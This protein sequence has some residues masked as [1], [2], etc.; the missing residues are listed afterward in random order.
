MLFNFVDATSISF[1]RQING[2]VLAPLAT[3]SNSTPIEGSVAVANFAQGG[4][5]HLGTFLGQG[6][7]D[8]SSRDPAR[9][10]ERSLGGGLSAPTPE[11]ATWAL[12]MIGIGMAGGA[13][14][15]NRN[16]TV[17]AA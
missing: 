15:R 13:L 14:R 16:G 5:V 12:M 17:R 1:N 10:L 9:G 3:I 11:P 8:G 4:E 7:I 6:L 2:S